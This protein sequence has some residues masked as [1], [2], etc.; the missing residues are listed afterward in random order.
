M[1]GNNP[2]AMK[3]I[4]LLLA[5]VVVLIS[6]QKD[7]ETTTLQLQMQGF[8]QSGK[9]YITQND[10]ENISCWTPN[11]FGDEFVRI[12]DSIY[13][14]FVPAGNSS[15]TISINDVVTADCYY[16]LYPTSLRRHLPISSSF[17]V[18]LPENEVYRTIN[19]SNKTLQLSDAPMAGKTTSNGL[20]LRPLEGMLACEITGSGWLEYIEVQSSTSPLSGPASITI[21]ND[22]VTLT[23]T[24][25]QKTKRLI[26]IHT[27]LSEQ[28]KT[29]YI[30]LPEFAAQTCH[31]LLGIKSTEDGVTHSYK[32]DLTQASIIQ[33]QIISFPISCPSATPSGFSLFADGSEYQPYIIHSANISTLATNATTNKHFILEEDITINSTITS[34]NGT[35][36]G[37]THIITLSHPLFSSL[38]GTV[39]NLTTSGNITPN[40][41]Q[42]N[43]GSIAEKVTESGAIINCI[44]NA[45]ITFSA[46]STSYVGGICGS[47]TSTTCTIQQCTNNGKITNQGT[48]TGGIIG[49]SKCPIL[50]CVNNGKIISNST[51]SINSSRYIGGICGQ[52]ISH[53]FNCSNNDSI[54]D[55][56][57]ASIQQDFFGGIVGCLN[58]SASIQITN[59]SNIGHITISGTKSIVGGIAGIASN[60]NILNCFAYCNI[61]AANFGGIIDCVTNS[62]TIANCYFHGTISNANYYKGI[63][64]R[65]NITSN[66]S[67]NNC[68]SSLSSLAPN[69][70]TTNC[71]TLSSPTTITGGGNLVDVLN[72][73]CSNITG[74]RS[75]TVQ[76]GIVVF[77]Q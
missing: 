32:K 46:N 24:G 8:S 61:N 67:I 17:D 35:L 25:N 50:N 1:A 45:N 43:F 77:A 59:C 5:P 63:V 55:T 3:K 37:N 72:S 9:T 33:G 56:R 4:L 71:N 34:F 19:Y 49:D 16:A 74:A 26:G 76:N 31:I 18:D 12:N 11:G 2:F 29:F 62:A 75:W 30:N 14:V 52:T 38:S 13:P 57:P 22:A 58:P 60:C 54:I 48:I 65:C 27:Q 21:S 41:G 10:E 44:N 51:Q 23:P 42:T 69:I 20:T 73:Y 36:D 7:Q 39:K 53:I 15:Q 70:T 6:C 40:G 64:R 47:T 66:A 28:P 68:Y